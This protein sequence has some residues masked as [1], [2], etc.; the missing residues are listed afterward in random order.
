LPQP[1][2]ATSGTSIRVQLSGAAPRTPGRLASLD[3]FRGLTIAGM[4]V[5][6]N[7]GT[8]SAI[9]PPL[10]HA[11]WHG[12]TPTDLI[13]PY[14]LFIVGVS[15][16]FSFETARSRGATR[17][18]LLA[19]TAKRS[20]I[21]FGLGLV[22][23]SFPWIGYDYSHLRIPGVLQRI[24]IAFSLAAVAVIW[25]RPRG[26]A[27]ATAALLIGYW[28]LLRWVPVP[29]VGAGVLEPGRDLGAY[30]DRLV[31]GT[32]HLWTQSRTWDPEGLLS[33][34]PAVAT[35]LLGVF[36]G[37]WLRSPRPPASK[38][39]GMLAAG[40]LATIAGLLWGLWFPINKPLWTSS[41]VL[42]TAGLALLSL[43]AC[44]WVVDAKGY[45]AWSL[46]FLVLGVNAIAA[47]FLSSLTARVMGSVDVGEISLKAWL[48][49]SL[50][51]SWLAPRN[52][53]L[54]FALAYTAAWSGLMALLYRHRI[55]IRV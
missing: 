36:A 23:H 11:E 7:P 9:Y 51:A 19:K 10:R 25:L 29:G 3:V 22:L 33:T 15:M 49:Q 35:V 17:A 20:L 32:R 48:H 52:A 31:F 4:L 39:R 1:A 16:S 30:L 12:W 5:V 43:A 6:N 26:R 37:D 55:F 2:A 45:R 42:L 18:A 46:P 14:F 28:A 13:F 54:A 21:L 41:Y 8:W 38:V 27:A 50:F 44:Y 24:A 40:A 47:F 53:S 34:L